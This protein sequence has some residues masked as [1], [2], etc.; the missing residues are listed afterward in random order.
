MSWP[1][2]IAKTRAESVLMAPRENHA[3][4]E[5]FVVLI[6]VKVFWHGSLQ[7]PPVYLS[8]GT[9]ALVY[10]SRESGDSFPGV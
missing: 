3:V 5:S 6:R 7:D 2:R 1:T 8:R 4:S 9:P 10:K